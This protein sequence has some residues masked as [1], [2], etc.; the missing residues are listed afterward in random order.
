MKKEQLNELIDT[1]CNEFCGQAPDLFQM[2]GIVVVG[3]RFG[4]RVVRLVVSRKIWMLTTRWFGDPK[5]WMPEHGPLAGRSV[6]LK[7][8]NTLGDYWDF[9]NGKDSPRD[10]LP[11]E[12]RK[13]LQ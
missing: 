12:T 10:A 7:I 11:A 9:I 2:V 8:L 5:V 3:H 1:V 13:M 4:W 6:G